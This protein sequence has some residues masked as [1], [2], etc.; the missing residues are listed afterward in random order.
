MKRLLYGF[1]GGAADG[2]A[3]AMR[4]TASARGA[5]ARFRALAALRS[6]VD[7][8]WSAVPSTTRFDGPVGASR[9]CRLRLGEHVRFGRGVWLETGDAGR[10]TI[11]RHVRLNAGTFVVSHAAVTIGD[12]VLIGEYVSIRDGNHGVAD[13]AAA[14]PMRLQPIDAEPVT[15]GDGAWIG[16]GATVLR[17]VTIGKE[18]VVAGN[19]VVTKD[20]PEGAVVAGVPAK[21]VRFRDGFGAEG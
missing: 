16:R 2:S 3:A 8:G 11:G 12:D 17:G 1:Y 15:I 5:W 19:A 18:A 7:R 9:G 14:G 10:I 21:V 20:V 13:P 6:R 4:L